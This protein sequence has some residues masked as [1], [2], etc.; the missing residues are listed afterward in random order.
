MPVMFQ[1]IDGLLW[2]T[3]PGWAGLVLCASLTGRGPSAAVKETGAVA[4]TV[5]SNGETPAAWQP[6]F[7]GIVCAAFIAWRWLAPA[8]QPR[9]SLISGNPSPATG[10]IVDKL[11]S[12]LVNQI[13]QSG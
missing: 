8:R 9:K 11:S 1:S 12:H 2:G 6:L 7:F 4:G 10:E 13:D 5:V 3:L